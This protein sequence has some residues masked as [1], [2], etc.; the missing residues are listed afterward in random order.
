M[1][2]IS[3]LR[4]WGVPT[5]LEMP[6]R[7]VDLA[8]GTPPVTAVATMSTRLS[9]G[10]VLAQKNGHAQYP[11]ASITKLLTAIIVEETIADLSAPIR[12]KPADIINPNL[13]FCV[14][15]GETTTFGDQL[16]GML[17]SSDNNAA[18]LLGRSTSHYLQ[19]GLSD[20]EAALRFLDL[21]KSR[22]NA[23]GIEVRSDFEW[24]YTSGVMSP[25]EVVLMLEHIYRHLPRTLAAMTT[26]S[27]KISVSTDDSRIRSY[28]A[29]STIRERDR[30]RLAG[31]VGAK[32]GTED[33]RGSVAIL[34]KPRPEGDVVA[35][36]V[37]QSSP[38]SAR[39]RDALRS[40]RGS[41]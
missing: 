17:I 26:R 9:D 3:A 38:H 5:L 11:I 41:V 25:K 23:L 15:A 22:A 2:P 14:Q 18:Q 20:Q 31:F 27:K 24:A 1:N 37:L 29:K 13:T 34:W 40:M 33:W 35:T 10:E 21:M 4:G 30:R 39:Y 19:P 12:V 8:G 16:D 32:T 36:V 6:R 28:T 7:A